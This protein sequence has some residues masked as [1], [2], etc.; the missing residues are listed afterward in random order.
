MFTVLYA[1]DHGW[2]IICSWQLGASVSK[3]CGGHRGPGSAICAERKGEQ[4]RH[5]DAQPWHLFPG[6]DAHPLVMSLWLAP[7]PLHNMS[8]E[9]LGKQR[10]D[11][12][13]AS[14]SA[15]IRLSD[16]KSPL[17]P[18]VILR[19]TEFA[20]MNNLFLRCLPRHNAM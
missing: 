9:T 5:T 1:A 15:C 7:P 3:G 13:S 17:C 18:G 12:S 16:I 6:G 20:E 2:M 14:Q 19:D 10:V 11:W 8:L 4:K